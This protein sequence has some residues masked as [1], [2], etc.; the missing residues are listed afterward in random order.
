MTCQTG[1]SFSRS[2]RLT[3]ASE[4]QKV[5]S[6][7]FRLGDDCITLLVSR[8]AAPQPRLGF[9]IAKKQLKHAVDRNRIK[10]LLRESFRQRQKDLPNRDVVVMVRNKIL[11]LSNREIFARLDKHWQYMIKRCENS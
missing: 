3:Q 5:F 1:E 8:K 6:K 4:Y 7:N 11:G 2:S 9:A 10:R